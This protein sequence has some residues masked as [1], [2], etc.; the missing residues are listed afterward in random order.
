MIEYPWWNLSKYL[1]P[2][3]AI[4]RSRDEQKSRYLSSKNWSVGTSTHFVG[5][6]AEFC[7]RLETGLA[8]DLEL[9]IDGDAGWDFAHAGTTYHAKGVTFWKS[10][11]LKEF[12]GR[13]K[14]AD[15]Y[16]LVALKDY[17]EAK[18]VGWSTREQLMN[19][20]ERNYGHGSMKSLTSAKLTEMGQLGLPPELPRR[21]PERLEEIMCRLKN[22]ADA[23]ASPSAA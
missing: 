16:I 20:P 8:M 17:R 6:C 1:S 3:K 23:D 21:T 4:A 18:V 2:L 15:R 13:K 22:Y 14:W 5:L 9:R 12:P 11:D 19:A 10:P 7:I